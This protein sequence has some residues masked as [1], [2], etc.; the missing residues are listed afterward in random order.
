MFNSGQL[1]NGTKVPVMS[2][3]SA[4]PYHGELPFRSSIFEHITDQRVASKVHVVK[5]F[6]LFD[7]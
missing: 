1:K 5:S 7:D 3:D 4:G 6:N 2:T